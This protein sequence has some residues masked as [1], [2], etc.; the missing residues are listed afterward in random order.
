MF[1][2]ERLAQF[3][4]VWGVRLCFQCAHI[5]SRNGIIERCHHTIKHIVTRTCHS[6]QEAEY[7][8]K[9]M[10]KDDEMASTAPA[11]LTYTYKIRLK[12]INA[13]LLQD[14]TISSPYIVG[15]AVWIKSLH[16]R[17][18]TQFDRSTATRIYSPHSVCVDRIPHHVKDICSVHGENNTASD[19]VTPLDPSD[20]EA[21]LII[22]EA[23]EENSSESSSFG[24]L[25]QDESSNTSKVNT[26]EKTEPV[27]LK[28]SSKQEPEICTIE[29]VNI[30]SWLT[31]R[32]IISPD[33]L[34][35]RR[36]Y[37]MTGS[38]QT[39]ILVYGRV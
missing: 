12:G 37:E 20:N 6:I 22:Y 8:H 36:H 30:L 2:R 35:K 7:W 5:P 28:W 25:K 23:V 38:K 19:H 34:E 3:A 13:A 33:T 4:E 21:D 15:D 10:P 39:A 29:A 18:M 26:T 17:C 16:E 1:C 27:P 11:N 32:A 14:N 9:V 31:G 24:D